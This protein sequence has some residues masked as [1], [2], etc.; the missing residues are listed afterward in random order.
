MLLDTFPFL[1]QFYS[2]E[3]E[4][5]LKIISLLF[6]TLTPGTAAFLAYLSY[7]S[8][9]HSSVGWQERMVHNEDQLNSGMT[10]QVAC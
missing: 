10:W 8:L 1:F 2:L 3:G 4:V 6:H 9:S 5:S 7:S